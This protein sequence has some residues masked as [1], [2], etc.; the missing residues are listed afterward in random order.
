MIYA[1]RVHGCILSAL[2][3]FHAISLSSTHMSGCANF[4]SVQEHYFSTLLAYHKL[5]QVR[6]FCAAI[7]AAE[8]V[9]KPTEQKVDSSA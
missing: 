6:F 5:E 7:S 8:R 1:W 2:A 9:R 3:L 4:L